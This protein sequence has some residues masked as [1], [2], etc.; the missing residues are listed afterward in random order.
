MKSVFVFHV[1][2]GNNLIKTS[3]VLKG[4]NLNLV[5]EK[6][7]VN[8]TIGVETCRM[9][10][11]S[12]TELKCVPPPTQPKGNNTEFPEVNVSCYHYQKHDLY[13]FYDHPFVLYQSWYSV[14]CLSCLNNHE[15]LSLKLL[16]C[17]GFHQTLKE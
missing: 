9:L 10:E 14:P 5:V 1:L 2:K 7:G 6:H 17:H 4:N 15:T 8:V 13:F 16:Q 11:L 3:F 12:A